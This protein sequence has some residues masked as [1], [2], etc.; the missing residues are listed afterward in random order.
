MSATC[1]FIGDLT[2]YFKKTKKIHLNIKK[3]AF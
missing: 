2:K 1:T 3:L